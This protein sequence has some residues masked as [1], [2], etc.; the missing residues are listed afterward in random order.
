MPSSTSMAKSAGKHK[1]LMARGKRI[2][3]DYEE[4]AK[5]NN[6]VLGKAPISG[7][8]RD[9]PKPQEPRA[10]GAMAEHEQMKRIS[11]KPSTS[12]NPY[13]SNK[14]TVSKTVK[15]AKGVGMKGAGAAVRALGGRAGLVGAAGAAGYAAGTA[16]Y[17]SNANK[18][19][20]YIDK[21][22]T[23]GNQYSKPRPQKTPRR[24]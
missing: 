17:S 6:K 14:G 8:R 18:I 10:R 4:I 24:K 20:D 23:G 12:G 19:Q 1:E 15:A 2:I 21:V 13:N 3:G 7:E 11:D 9:R 5:A 16:I 22:K